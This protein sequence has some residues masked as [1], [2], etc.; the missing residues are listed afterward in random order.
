M[1]E[2]GAKWVLGRTG[3]LL[4][5]DYGIRVAVPRFADVGRLAARADHRRRHRAGDDQQALTL[6]FCYRWKRRLH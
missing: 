1:V 3:V 6:N 2:R 5:P 4:H